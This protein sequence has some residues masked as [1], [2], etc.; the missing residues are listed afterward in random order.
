MNARSAPRPFGVDASVPWVVGLDDGAGSTR[1]HYELG[2]LR[3]PVRSLFAFGDLA[4]H[5]AADLALVRDATET[6]ERAGPSE[7]VV[8]VGARGRADAEIIVAPP[9]RFA[10]EMQQRRAG[11]SLFDAVAGS[12]AGTA[13][14]TARVR[15]G[16]RRADRAPCRRGHVSWRTGVSRKGPIAPHFWSTS[17]TPSAVAIEFGERRVGGRQPQHR[18]VDEERADRVGLPA[19]DVGPRSRTR[20]SSGRRGPCRPSSSPSPG[21]SGSGTCRRRS[22]STVCR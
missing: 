7:A 17:I 15:W 16:S 12:S 18:V 10:P 13:S 8:E 20:A 4:G 2:V 9:D 11:D 22:R 19:K 21:S 1:S 6:I 5:L 3:R 14:R